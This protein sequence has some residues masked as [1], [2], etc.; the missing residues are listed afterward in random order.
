EILKNQYSALGADQYAQNIIE[1]GLPPGSYPIT[2]NGEPV[3]VTIAALPPPAPPPPAADNSRRLQASKVVTPTTAAASTLT[4]FTYTITVTNGDD[5]SENLNKIHDELPAGF[6]YVA[7][8]TSG[9]TTA[10]PSI[11]GQQLTW[12]PGLL[13]NPGT[14]VTLTFDAQASLAQGNYCNEAWVEP[15]K[16]KTSS[17]LTARIEVGSPGDDLCPGKAVKVTKTVEVAAGTVFPGNPVTFTYTITIE[18]TGTEDLDM[19]QVRDLLPVGFTY[20]PGTTSGDITVANPSTTMQQG[21]QRLTWDFSP[22]IEIEQSG[23]PKKTLVFDVQGV[24][25]GGHWN[26]AWATF[27]EFPDTIYTW[28]TAA[29]QIIGVT[30]STSV[31]ADGTTVYSRLQQIGPDSYILV[32]WEISG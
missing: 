26:E 19:T 30:E 28:P 32:E 9:V 23:D 15:G 11:V 29:V 16:T 8:S 2:L 17:G 3:A 4:T 25:T 7:G 18:N 14:S 31:T 27:D 21:R 20:V 1:Q 5:E 24:F 10:D 6:S 13:L 22:E 12:S